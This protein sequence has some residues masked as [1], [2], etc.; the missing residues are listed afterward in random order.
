VGVTLN[1]RRFEAPCHFGLQGLIVQVKP[2][3]AYLS[4]QRSVVELHNYEQPK[5]RKMLRFLAVY[6]V[7]FTVLQDKCDFANISKSF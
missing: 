7:H 6:V 2:E 1:F 3:A 5:T 4:A